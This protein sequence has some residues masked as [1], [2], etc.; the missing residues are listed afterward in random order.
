MNTLKRMWL[1]VVQP[2]DTTRWALEG[3]FFTVLLLIP[4]AIVILTRSAWGFLLYPFFGL[5]AWIRSANRR[6]TK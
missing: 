1:D 5:T 3:M 2:G 4:F 6:S